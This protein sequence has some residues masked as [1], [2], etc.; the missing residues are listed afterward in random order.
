MQWETV[1]ATG[2]SAIVGG[3]IV[4]AVTHFFTRRREQNKLRVDKSM[5]RRVEAWRHIERLT[6]TDLSLANFE[7]VVADVILFGNEREINLVTALSKS[8][9]TK[10]I[11]D[12]TPLLVEL[13]RNIR[14]DLGLPDTSVEHFFF[15]E[16][17]P[18]HGL[19]PGNSS[20]AS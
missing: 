16:D 15:R 2:S 3:L 7:Q 6:G 1:A 12:L 5:D 19:I 18:K 9:G 14:A 20:R 11:T 13:R 8:V 17:G 10:G 4:A